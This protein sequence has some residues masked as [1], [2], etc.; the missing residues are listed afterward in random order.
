M[1]V[2]RLAGYAFHVNYL[3]H[4]NTYFAMHVRNKNCAGISAI[5]PGPYHMSRMKNTYTIARFGCS[6]KEGE[7]KERHD[8]IKTGEK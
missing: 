8:T 1:H 4:D 2:V 7:K 5:R 3:F 6:S